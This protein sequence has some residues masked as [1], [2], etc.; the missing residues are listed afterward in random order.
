MCNWKTLNKPI[1]E[2][3][4]DFINIETQSFCRGCFNSRSWHKIKNGRG[5]SEVWWRIGNRAEDGGERWAEDGKNRE[6]LSESFLECS[7]VGLSSGGSQIT[8]SLSS[9]DT[10]KHQDIL[11]WK[12]RSVEGGE[13]ICKTGLQA[14][15]LPLQGLDTA[16]RPQ[17]IICPHFPKSQRRFGMTGS[18][19]CSRKEGSCT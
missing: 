13:N 19:C 6:W 16:V 14:D 2:R 15:E 5:Q 12:K 8:N 4:N 1:R 10:Y 9:Q 3:K 17:G 11:C 18:I 7:L